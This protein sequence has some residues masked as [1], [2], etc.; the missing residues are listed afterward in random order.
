[1]FTEQLEI[2]LDVEIVHGR[3]RKMVFIHL[4][5]VLRVK[6]CFI[7]VVKVVKNRLTE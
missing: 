2:S 4:V 6:P 3:Q 5:S 7:Y 1:M